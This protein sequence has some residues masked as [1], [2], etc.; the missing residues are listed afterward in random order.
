[1]HRYHIKFMDYKAALLKLQIDAPELAETIAAY[2]ASINEESATRRIELRDAQVL[3][4]KLKQVAGDV[5]L[6][7]LVTTTKKQSEDTTITA[8]NLQV[9]LEAALL[10]AA[11]EQRS[12]K[13]LKAAQLSGAD[14]EALKKLLEA[15]E[16]D[17]IAVDTE[18]K[19]D[20]KPLPEFADSQGKFWQNALF[21]ANQNGAVPTGG[22]TPAD[23]VTPAGNYLNNQAAMLRKTLGGG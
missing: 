2:V 10:V 4:E 13:L 18:V 16:N 5:D 8:N 15:V 7:E 3:I 19:I 21:P 11:T 9:R 14:E 17:K 6:L 20:G 1:M 23:E 22:K 12:Y